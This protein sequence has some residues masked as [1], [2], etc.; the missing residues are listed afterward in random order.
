MPRCR[1]IRFDLLAKLVDIDPQVLRIDRCITPYFAQQVLVGQHLAGVD[2]EL[3]ED[4]V[5]L[6]RELHVLGTAPHQPAHQVDA[7]IVA[8]EDALDALF[9]QAVAKGCPDTRLELVGAERLGD[10]VVG[11]RIERRHL[12]R[13]VAAARQNDDRHLAGA[14]DLRNQ[15]Q[16]IDVR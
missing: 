9:L 11:A 7:K 6:G 15:R 4:V 1:R 8:G 5:L 14:A 10:M 13:L 16:P 12:G 2:H 3:L